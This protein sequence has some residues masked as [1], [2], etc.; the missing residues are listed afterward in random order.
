[1]VNILISPA[2]GCRGFVILL[3]VTKELSREVS[4]GSE[5]SSSND[6]AVNFRK[7][8]FDGSGAQLLK[9]PVSCDNCRDDG[10]DLGTRSVQGTAL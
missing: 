1:M 7:P 2:E 10:T 8:D 6:R 3:D 4:F 9:G 5:G